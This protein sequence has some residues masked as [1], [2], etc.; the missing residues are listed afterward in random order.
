VIGRFKHYF[1]F[2]FFGGKLPKGIYLICEGFLN[3]SLRK[4]EFCLPERERE[5]EKN[6]R[7]PLL[8]FLIQH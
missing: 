2:F 4:T 8:D 3:S 5:R 1:F 7:V 6:H